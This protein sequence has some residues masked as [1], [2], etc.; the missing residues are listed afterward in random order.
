MPI[1]E[2]G[3][4]GAEA[5]AVAANAGQRRRDCKQSSQLQRWMR[6]HAAP[7]AAS[8]ACIRRSWMPGNRM[9]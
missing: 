5:L 6:R 2:R 8:R 3:D 9:R 1:V 4:V 7:G